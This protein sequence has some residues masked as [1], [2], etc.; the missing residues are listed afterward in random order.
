MLSPSLLE[1]F[2][3]Y[4]IQFT[5]RNPELCLQNESLQNPLPCLLQ[6]YIHICGFN[7]IISSVMGYNLIIS[8]VMAYYLITYSVITYYMIISSVMAYYLTI[9]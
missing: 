3:R 1:Y 6:T 9:S 5:S 8:S 7:L 4:I 2:A